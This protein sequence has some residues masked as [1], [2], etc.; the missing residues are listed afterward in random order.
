MRGK[1][2]P[3]RKID[4]DPKYNN[5]NVAKF[6]NF[7]MLDGKKSVARGIVYGAFDI[8]EEKTK[9]HPVE[10]FEAAMKNIAPSVEVRARRIGGANYQVPMEVRP[11]RKFALAGRWVLEA[12]RAGKGKPMT[13]KLANELMAAIENEGEAY[14]KKEEM[15]RMAEANRAFAH[16]A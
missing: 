16:F 14:K 6:I 2:A 12:T 7:L 3:K 13:V 4:P 9:K 1:Q 8:I 10:V 11:D 5:T 15:H